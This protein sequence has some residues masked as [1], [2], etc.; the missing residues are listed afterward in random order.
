MVLDVRHIIKLEI[1]EAA[2]VVAEDILMA[3]NVRLVMTMVVLAIA[4]KHTN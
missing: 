4:F 1:A 2:H 3:K